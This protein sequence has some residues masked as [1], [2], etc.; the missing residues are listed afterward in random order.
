MINYSSVTVSNHL[1][2]NV[3]AYVFSEGSTWTSGPARPTRPLWHP[4]VRWNRCE[5]PLKFT[6]HILCYKDNHCTGEMA[7]L[8]LFCSTRGLPMEGAANENTPTQKELC[9]EQRGVF[10]KGSSAESSV[11]VAVIWYIWVILRVDYTQAGYMC[12]QLRLLMETHPKYT[13]KGE[14][15]QFIS[16]YRSDWFRYQNNNHCFFFFLKPCTLDKSTNWTVQ[17]LY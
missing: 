9:S 4:W 15:W 12:C 7:N 1:T 17:G 13:G 5:Y 2:G 11:C 10:E 3:F 16:W 8:S 6:T 14:F